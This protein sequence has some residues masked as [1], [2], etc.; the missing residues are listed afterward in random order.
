MTI[1][2]R[3][4]TLAI[5]AMVVASLPLHSEDPPATPMP[6]GG[7]EAVPDAASPANCPDL[8]GSWCGTWSS[9]VNGHNGPMNATF[10]R[11]CDGHYDVTFKGRFWKLIPFHYSTTLMVTGVKDGKV[12]L[13]GSHHLGPLLGT[14]SYNAWADGC[15]FVSSY[16]ARRDN[17]QFVM[18]RCCRLKARMPHAEAQRSRRRDCEGIHATA[19]SASLREICLLDW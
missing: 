13:S 5:A 8:S 12:Y 18:S 2:L 3:T 9:C 4:A 6:D 10:C 11:R 7:Y 15:Q 14:F 16:C 19:V 17:G 1:W